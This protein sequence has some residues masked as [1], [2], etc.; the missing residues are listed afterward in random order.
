MG[1]QQHRRSKSRNSARRAEI[2][3]KTAPSIVICPKCHEY[4]R[5]HRACPACGYYNDKVSVPV[6]NAD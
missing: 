6:K 5:S 4:K 2:L 3:K 1:V